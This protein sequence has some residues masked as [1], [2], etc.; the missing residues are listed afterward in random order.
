MSPIGTLF[1]A[2]INIFEVDNSLDT[3]YSNEDVSALMS[4]YLT[5]ALNDDTDED[6]IKFEINVEYS[7][8]PQWAMDIVKDFADSARQNLLSTMSDESGMEQEEASGWL[9]F[10][11]IV[12]H[13]EGTSYDFWTECLGIDLS[14]ISFEKNK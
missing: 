3:R 8:M 1:G 11:F 5:T 14:Q 4:E 6:G 10:F 13:Y 9:N 2:P 7:R 12:Q